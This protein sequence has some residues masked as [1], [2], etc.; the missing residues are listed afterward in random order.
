MINNKKVV[1]GKVR[2]SYV[3]IFEARPIY[4][5]KA[6]Y[7]LSIIIPKS[8]EKTVTEIKKAISLAEEMARKKFGLVK[9]KKL[10]TPLRDGDVEKVGNP[11]Y[12]NSFFINTKSN[13]KPQVVDIHLNEIKN[14]DEV[15]S[16]CYGRVSLS[17]Y[18][19]QFNNNAGVAC[20]LGN[21]QKL[22][23]GE[24]LDLS[25]TAKDDFESYDSDGFF[26]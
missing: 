25:T 18:P 5:D 24:R 23:D 16:G 15:Y 20:N 11:V 22:A 4:D 12:K 8:D 10:R 13:T 19:Y 6:K 14:K 7:S 17:F 2:L 1:T 3:N 9:S 21:V 26:S